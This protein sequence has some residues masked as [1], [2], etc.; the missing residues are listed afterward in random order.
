MEVATKRCPFHCRFWVNTSKIV[1]PLMDEVD[2]SRI[3][4]GSAHCGGG[5]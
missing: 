3:V 1:S 5:I 4:P 2:A